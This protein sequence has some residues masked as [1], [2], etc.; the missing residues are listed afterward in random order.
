[1]QIYLTPPYYTNNNANIY[2]SFQVTNQFTTITYSFMELLK[3]DIMHL[4]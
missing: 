4:Y 1:M 2:T 3:T